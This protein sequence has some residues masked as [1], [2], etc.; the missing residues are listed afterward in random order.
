MGSPKATLV[1]KGKT[2]LNALIQVSI[3]CELNP[4]VVVLGAKSKVISKTIKSGS[5]NLRIVTN[6]EWKSGQASSLIKGINILTEDIDGALILLVDQPQV[7]QSHLENLLETF[8]IC[9]KPI[10]I[11]KEGDKL[12]PPTL[13]GKKLFSRVAMLRGD[14]GAKKLLKEFDYEI[15]VTDID[16]FDI[17]T[18]DD[19]NKLIYD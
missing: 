11:T 15:V 3:D 7:S 1:W 18:K 4:I 2:F 10:I 17:D 13:I 16:L 12:S 14:E 8:Y 19:Y 6:E 9:K 5:K